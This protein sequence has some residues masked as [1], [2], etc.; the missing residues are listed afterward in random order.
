MKVLVVKTSSLGDVIHTLPALSDARDAIPDIEFDW[1]VEEAFAQIPSW[2]KAV[3]DVM[4]CALRRWRKSLWQTVR[5]GEWKAFKTQLQAKQ[6]DAVIDAQGLIK[7]AFITKRARGQ[8]F[9]LDKQS[10]REGLSARVLDKPQAVALGQHAVERNRQLFA[11]SLGYPYSP[12]TPNYGLMFTA[13][14][15]SEP[16]VALLHGTTWESK[17]WP[18]SYWQQ[19]AELLLAQGLAV[20]L[21][22][23]N[24]EE[25]LR[26]QQI[27][28]CSDD[29][30]IVPKMP[31]QQVAQ[32]LTNATAAV[33]VD[34]GLGHL[35]AA[36]DVPLVAIYGATDARLTGCYGG[37][38]EVLSADYHCSPCMQ[39]QCSEPQQELYPP[40]YKRLDPETVLQCLKRVKAHG[41]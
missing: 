28:Q 7:S 4:P 37:R 30:E 24:E 10:A 35:A 18:V 27:A 19:L 13:E 26:A 29:I 34:T 33:S 32:W 21:S 3:N 31:L 15:V 38:V 39:K 11:Q 6:Y 1:V 5:Q 2:H 17:L 23:G 9:G 36:L 12:S 8:K 41:L 14:P 20:Q 16:Y 25:K 40:C 22:W